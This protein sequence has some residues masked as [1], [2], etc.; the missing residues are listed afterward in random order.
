M[1]ALSE[2]THYVS[3]LVDGEIDFQLL[4]PEGLPLEEAP[5]E[6]GF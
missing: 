4:G 5:P 1:A 6:P 2:V 3:I